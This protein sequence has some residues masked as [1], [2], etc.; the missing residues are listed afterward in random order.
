M[1]RESGTNCTYSPLH[2]PNRVLRV[3]VLDLFLCLD[4]LIRPTCK[5]TFPTSAMECGNVRRDLM[6]NF[7]T[8]VSSIA[9]QNLFIWY[10]LNERF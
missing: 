9:P 6:N 10:S 3:N 8:L 4:H 7:E 2:A 5:N 1:K